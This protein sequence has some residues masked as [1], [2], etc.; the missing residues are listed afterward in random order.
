MTLSN[1]AR[2]RD[3][4]GYHDGAECAPPSPTE[5]NRGLT[6]TESPSMSVSF[7]AKAMDAFRTISVRRRERNDAR[8]YS[9]DYKRIGLAF[10]I[11]FVVIGTSLYAAFLFAQMY[12]GGDD[13]AKHMMMLAP[14][15]YALIELCR[16]PLA[17][18]T[19]TQRSLVIR[20]LAAIGVVAA[21]GV[22][23]KSMSQLGEIMFRPRLFEVVRQHE[24]LIEAQNEHAS[25]MK[26]IEDADATV[27]QLTQELKDAEKHLTEATTAVAGLPP[28]RCQKLRV[29]GR[30]ARRSET[31]KC[32]ADPRTEAMKKNLQQATTARD[33]VKGKLDAAR[34]Q[35]AALKREDVDRALSDA[36]VAHKDAVLHSQL[37]SFTA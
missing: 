10:L 25:L 28:P 7:G 27:E 8:G 34:G 37:H 21:M 14:V 9:I 16:V 11:E 31:M 18:S 2:L 15:G 22:T 29:T 32:T 13:I 35:R 3:A 19:R 4:A 6:M 1:E 36:Q 12:G 5:R 26:R 24:L 20:A 33:A 17:L 30:N 23:V